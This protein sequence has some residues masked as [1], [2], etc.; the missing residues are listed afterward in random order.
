MTVECAQ[1]GSGTKKKQKAAMTVA[2]DRHGTAVG[3]GN[4]GPNGKET[5]ISVESRETIESCFGGI[6]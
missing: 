4:L 6:R 1:Q 2:F 5:K 3:L